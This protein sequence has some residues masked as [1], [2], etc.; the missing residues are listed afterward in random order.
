MTNRLKNTGPNP[1]E[2]TRRLPE[3]PAREPLAPP[4]TRRGMVDHIARVIETLYEPREARAIALLVVSELAGI[5]VSALLTYPGAPLRIEGLDTVVAQLTLGRPVQY[6]LGHTEF[7]GHVF[8][9]REGVLIPRPE[10]EELVAWIV[11]REGGHTTGDAVQT[12]CPIADRALSLLDVGTGSGCIAASLACALPRAKVY[13]TDVSD[14]ALTI[15]AENFGALGV[16][17]V[18]RRS[19]ALHDVATVFPE[20]FDVIVSNP[21]YVPQSDAEAMHRNVRDYEPHRALFVPDDDPLRFYRAIARAAGQMLRR[22]GRLYF[23]IY[24]PY[25]DAVCRL[26]TDEGYAQT[27]IREDLNGKQRMICSRLK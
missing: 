11:E 7:C 24:A 19:D 5:S 10:T 2:P 15:A 16:P 25:A 4:S 3:S 1:F 20:R 13:A 17:V 22:G 12:E 23:E 21:P 14:V 26:L 6:V 27:E 8:S 9:V 18:L